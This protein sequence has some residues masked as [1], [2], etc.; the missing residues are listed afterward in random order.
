LVSEIDLEFESRVLQ[1]WTHWCDGLE[2][3]GLQQERRALVLTPQHFRYEFSAHELRVQF[4]LPPGQFATAV[5]REMCIL[6]NQQKDQPNL[7]Q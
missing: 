2:H 6:I 3:V 1:L 7:A 4:N 5:L